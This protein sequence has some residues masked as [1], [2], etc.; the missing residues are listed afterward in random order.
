M[1]ILIL[2]KYDHDRPIIVHGPQFDTMDKLL[3]KDIDRIEF[4]LLSPDEIRR[5]SVTEVRST[6]PLDNLRRPK[7]GGLSDPQMGSTEGSMVCQTCWQNMS[8]CPGHFGHIELAR[9]VY[10]IHY[11]HIIKKVLECICLRCAHVRLD[12]DDPM[13]RRIRSF[14]SSRHKFKVLWRL[15]KSKGACDHAN[16][17]AQHPQVR[18]S[19]PDIVISRQRSRQAGVMLGTVD[20]MGVETR[21]T[22]S[23]REVYDILRRIPDADCRLMGLDP[24]RS[25]PEWMVLTVLPVPPPC[26]RPSVSMGNGSKG[27]DDLT[28]LLK[29][30]LQCSNEIRKNEYDPVNQT[31]QLNETEL[32]KLVSLYFDSDTNL[33]SSKNCH[34]IGKAVKGLKVRLSGK[35]GR[36][37]GYLMGK[38]VDFTAR[39][40]ITGDANLGIDQVGV[41]Y[42][43]AMNLT[44]PERVTQYNIV[45]LQAVVDNG[46]KNYPGAN[47]WQQYSVDGNARRIYLALRKVPVVLGVGDVV[48]RHLLDGDLVLFNRQPTLHRPSMMAHSVRVMHGKTFRL[49]LSVTTPYNADFDGDEMNL[50][51]CQGLEA[52]AELQVLSRVSEMIVSPQANKP[53]MGIVQDALCGV[54]KMTLRDRFFTKSQLCNLLLKLP[55]W[56]GKMPAPSILKPKQLWTGKALFSMLLPPTLNFYGKHSTHSDSDKDNVGDTE[57]VIEDGALLAGIICKKSVGASAGGII[58]LI[59]NDYGTDAAKNFFNGCQYLVN[60]FMLHHGFSVG[61]G[62]CLI[63]ASTHA[64]IT[65]TVSDAMNKVNYLIEQATGETMDRMTTDKL[66]NEI[67]QTLAMARDSSG[68]A[69]D[70]ALPRDNNFK[71]M[72]Q[73]GSKGSMINISQISGIVGQQNVEGG[74]IPFAMRDR[75]LPFFERGDLRPSAKGFVAHSYIDGLNPTEFFFHA[76]GGREG[77]I[78]TACKTAE[79]GYIQRKLVKALEDVSVSYDDTVRTAGHVVIQFAY[80]EE[81]MDAI[82][83]ERQHVGLMS[84]NNDAVRRLTCIQDELDQLFVDRAYLQRVFTCLDGTVYAPVHF[85]RI[86]KRAQHAKYDGAVCE[87]RFVYETVTR[88]LESLP[89]NYPLFEILTRYFLASNVIC[90]DLALPREALMWCLDLIR[91][92]FVKGKIDAGEAV[93]VI[94]AQ[95][96]G[97]PT[98]QMTLNSVEWDTELLLCNDGKMQRTPIGEYIDRRLDELV[99]EDLERNVHNDTTLG[100]IKDENVTVLSINDSGISSWNKVEALTRHPVINDDGSRGIVRVTL[101][102]GRTVTATRGESFLTRK[103]NKLV[104]T[105]GDSLVVGDYLPVQRQLKVPRSGNKYLDVAKFL[106]QSAPIPA[107]IELDYDFGWYF[108]TYLNQGKQTRK[109]YSPHITPIFKQLFGSFLKRIPIELVCGP[110]DFVRGMLIGYFGDFDGE[111]KQNSISSPTSTSRGMLEDI[112]VC[113]SQFGIQGKIVSCVAYSKPSYTLELDMI[114]SHLFDL[115]IK[116]SDKETLVKCI[117][118]DVFYDQIVDIQQVES[119]WNY[120]YDLTVAET[121]N[122]ATYSGVHM[123]DTFHF[124]GVGN[125][126]VSTGVGR[127]K[128]L[129]NDLKN[130]K[131]P[132]MTIYLTPKYCSTQA[133]AN[134]VAKKLRH[135]SFGDIV[136][137]TSIVYDADVRNC[138][139]AG[140]EFFTNLFWNTPYAPLDPDVISPWL[141]RFLIRRDKLWELDLSL[142]ELCELIEQTMEHDVWC[143]SS[144][145]N[146]DGDLV[147]HVR[148]ELDG[149]SSPETL[150]GDDFLREVQSSLLEHLTLRGI[151][152]IEAVLVQKK[153]IPIIHDDGNITYKDEWY[154]ETLG[155]NL[156][157]VVGIIGVD[158]SRL[159]C[160][161]PKDMLQAYGCEAARACLLKEIRG[162]IEYDGSYV[163]YRHLALLCDVMTNRGQLM[164]VTRHGLNRLNSGPLKKCTFEESVDVLMDAAVNCD[165]DMLQ[166]VSES[167][168]VG[169]HIPTGSGAVSIHW[170]GV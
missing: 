2:C 163:N 160:N 20:E 29:S 64:Q 59:W 17:G 158:R 108:G 129:I 113:L 88:F 151:P 96:I 48:E 153:A 36:I 101:R 132:T 146:C 90:N 91:Q 18:L 23:T 50:H 15:V 38:R 10:H 149:E 103:G 41:P 66:E 40:V 161:D 122:F 121:K 34:S 131:T 70:E 77:L 144:D 62:D 14:S 47:Y 93:G 84:M 81:G 46:P 49:N 74:R 97:E 76:M 45:K 80:G 6:E 3:N 42:E 130:F 107:T 147:I 169:Q 19:G 116:S 94:A 87:P 154:I 57:V 61:L 75:A 102:S 58:H 26:V 9:P 83:V 136:S 120:V 104:A 150:S 56:N 133:G 60:E 89:R 72:V 112:Q 105:R 114:N 55:H 12:H 92:K 95:S 39:T 13:H 137:D 166:G 126:L 22:L 54:R 79:T 138:S 140:D 11:I 159:Y 25:R 4:G 67:T 78:D 30:I 119:K 165:R 139:I 106:K 82:S 155:I 141:L 170:N 44:I 85:K 168:L 31:L 73:S 7:V 128:E 134:Q 148:Y 162:V 1:E 71:Q 86:L 157:A 118:E 111:S 21:R 43:V 32:A 5:Y 35:N 98:T 53:V 109:A 117:E 68:K 110:L 156:T 51:V 16:C 63:D 123:R 99:E 145:D 28:Y 27:E 37:R 24:L 152:E 69:A 164:S 52:T 33:F 135:V 143:L 125:Q 142:G 100:W 65:L 167:I 124:S 115:N 8:M 127:L